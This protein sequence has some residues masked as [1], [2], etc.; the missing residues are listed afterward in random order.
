MDSSRAQT[1]ETVTYAMQQTTNSIMAGNFVMNVI[2]S[3]SLQQLWSMIN[4]QQIIVLMPLFS[5]QMPANAQIFYGFIM[6]LASFNILPMDAFYEKYL[7]APSWDKPLDDMFNNLGFQST[8]FLNNMG[9]MVLGLAMVPLLSF[10]L[11]VLKPL[12]KYSHRISTLKSKIHSALF[13]SQQITL[14]NE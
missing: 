6:N 8:F 3:A 5:S 7:P 2:L 12:S 1:I 14:M 11:L 4:T 10:V 9:S 13:W